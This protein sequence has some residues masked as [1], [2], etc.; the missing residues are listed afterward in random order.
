MLEHFFFNFLKHVI[1]LIGW[2]GS[3]KTFL[4][5]ADALGFRGPFET[6]RQ[7]Q[8]SVIYEDK[9]VSSA[10]FHGIKGLGTELTRRSEELARERG[11]THTYAMVTG[12][13]KPWIMLQFFLSGKYSAQIFEKLGHTLLA[14][15][16]YDEF[17][18][19]MGELML[20]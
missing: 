12:G 5:L 9:A 13:F 3:L 11:C 2:P 6:M 4:S 18:D 15:V 19:E 17:R 14:K 8:C 20:R 10:R 16:V 7:L 1:N